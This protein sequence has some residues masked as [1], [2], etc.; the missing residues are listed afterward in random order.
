MVCFLDKEFLNVT[1]CLKLATCFFSD[2]KDVFYCKETTLWTR[3]AEKSNEYERTKLCVERQ[4]H[5][6]RKGTGINGTPLETLT[7]DTRNKLI[8]FH[9]EPL[10]YVAQQN[11]I[12]H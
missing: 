5:E 3:D 10:F 4:L 9:W 8:F 11:P 1:K 7:L 12:K 2:K 6:F